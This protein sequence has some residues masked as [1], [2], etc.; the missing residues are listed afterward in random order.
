[1]KLPSYAF[2][3]PMRTKKLRPPRSIMQVDL[4]SFKEIRLDRIPA[5]TEYERFTIVLIANMVDELTWARE[6]LGYA[7]PK[8]KIYPIARACTKALQEAFAKEIEKGTEPYLRM[9][10]KP[11]RD[12]P[13]GRRGLRAA[14]KI[15]KASKQARTRYDTVSECKPS[16]RA[17]TSKKTTRKT[18]AAR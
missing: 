18:R 2:G 9:S 10:F 4:E 17:R 13:E 7:H 8:M 6:A 3:E 14:K 12:T 11:R 16:T 15:L 1:M 5:R